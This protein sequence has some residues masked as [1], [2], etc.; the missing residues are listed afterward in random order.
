MGAWRPNLST[1][2]PRGRPSIGKTEMPRTMPA[3]GRC[4]TCTLI[5]RRL[6]SS[7]QRTVTKEL[8][9]SLITASGL[10]P[11]VFMRSTRMLP[12]MAGSA[13]RAPGETGCAI[14]ARA[15]GVFMRPIA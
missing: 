4:T 14:D 12:P 10:N 11:S 2:L 1:V 6:A 9:S 15:F 5:A 3:P 13:A 8:P 7:R